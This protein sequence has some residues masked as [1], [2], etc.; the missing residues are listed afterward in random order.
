[1]TVYFHGNFGLHRP[2]MAALLERA[3]ANPMMRDKELAE[4]FGYGTPYG[5]RYRSWL[6]K[7]GIIELDFPVRLTPKGEVVWQHDPKLET[8]TTQWFMH[9]ELT[10]DPT[11]A[12]AWHWFI[13]EFLP[14]H[15]TFTREDLMNGLMI[16]LQ[17]HSEKHFGPDSKLTPVIARKL[18]ECY[19][20]KVALGNL[21]Y[22]VLNDA[23]WTF[24][25]PNNV[26][27]PWTATE[28][29]QN[30]YK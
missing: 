3:L 19:T 7:T 25:L 21:N 23:K 20:D 28:V 29:I 4:P 24:S 27:G 16:K 26:R 15:P 30:A 2:R 10:T 6:H 17:P 5:Q 1:M 9:W 14:S 13:H 8:L 22:I 12:E 11:R 18:I